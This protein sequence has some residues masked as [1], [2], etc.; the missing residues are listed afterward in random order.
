[1]RRRRRPALDHSPS[2]GGRE[3]NSSTEGGGGRGREADRDAPWTSSSSYGTTGPEAL[4][5]GNGP[6]AAPTAR[7]PLC[8]SSSPLRPLSGDPLLPIGGTG[9]AP[10][11]PSPSRY[12]EG[13]PG[14]LIYGVYR[15]TSHLRWSAG[16][17]PGSP[18]ASERTRKLARASRSA[19]ASS[20]V[21]SAA[22]IGGEHLPSLADS[23]P[24]QRG[25]VQTHPRLSQRDRKGFL[26]LLSF[27]PG[28]TRPRLRP[29]RS[30]CLS[31]E[32]T[33]TH[34]PLFPRHLPPR[35]TGRGPSTRPARGR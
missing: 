7:P 8:N 3:G 26:L 34:A 11:P 25:R 13:D 32:R 17:G 27:Q 1:M 22:T 30:V 35:A 21:R 16:D 24:R 6:L 12:R 18:P 28:C 4:S 2:R 15:G 9:I 29:T 5:P 33:A 23:M 20:A 14:P 10:P 31:R 19:N